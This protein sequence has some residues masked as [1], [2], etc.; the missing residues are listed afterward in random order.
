MIT[1]LA[2]RRIATAGKEGENYFLKSD[3]VRK[4]LRAAATWPTRY[5]ELLLHLLIIFIGLIY[6]HYR[7]CQRDVPWNNFCFRE[8]R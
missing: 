7:V 1:V 2:L 3:V 8:T 4:G 5:G 6:A